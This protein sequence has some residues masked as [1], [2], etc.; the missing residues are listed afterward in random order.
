[1][2]KRKEPFQ[3]EAGKCYINEDGDKV[4]PLRHCGDCFDVADKGLQ[5]ELL[6]EAD[7]TGLGNPD[8]VS[9]WVDEGTGCPDCGS[10]K[11][12]HHPNCIF[13]SPASDPVEERSIFDVKPDAYADLRQVLML[14]LEQ[15]SGGKG[16]QRH[17]QGKPFDRQPMLEI[18]R[19]LNGSPIGCMYQA[20]KKTQEASRMDRGAAKREL[21]GAINY[22][23]GAYLLLEE[24]GD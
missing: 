18:S 6:Y 20:I 23:A 21:L 8:L 1:M 10:G 5:C 7:G 15:A 19:M 22:L 16:A 4:G 11:D 24:S 14:A 12:F 17:G 9:E 13:G 2:A 3:L